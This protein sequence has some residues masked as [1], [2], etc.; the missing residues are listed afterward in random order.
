MVVPIW[1]LVPWNKRRGWQKPSFFSFYEGS[2]CF[3]S[4]SACRLLMRAIASLNILCW[5]SSIGN[6]AY[7][8]SLHLPR[9]MCFIA[10]IIYLDSIGWLILSILNCM[11]WKVVVI[12]LNFSEE[13]TFHQ[14]RMHWCFGSFWVPVSFFGARRGWRSWTIFWSA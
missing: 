1:F 10:F 8:H 13:R 9:F 12:N 3:E 6:T 14:H 11:V 2:Y 4:F 7:A 5:H